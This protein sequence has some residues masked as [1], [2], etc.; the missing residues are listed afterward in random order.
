MPVANELKRS[1]I[2]AVGAEIGDLEAWDSIIQLEVA[3]R[4]LPLLPELCR[5]K[6]AESQFENLDE[7]L[8]LVDECSG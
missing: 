4:V 8:S 2:D 6:V 1:V 7:L 3:S 5:Y